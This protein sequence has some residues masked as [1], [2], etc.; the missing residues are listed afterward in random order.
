MRLHKRWMLIGIFWFRI[1]A[2]QSISWPMLPFLKQDSVNPI[3][4]P[5]SAKE[6]KDPI[7][8]QPVRWMMHNVLNPAAIVHGGQI[9]LLFRA[10]D[11]SPLAPTGTSRIGL[12]SSSDGLHFHILPEPV[13]F[14]DTDSMHP[15]EWPGG[16]EDP[17][18]VEREDGLYV[19]TY[20]AYDGHTA[21]LC[22]ATSRD[23]I[24]WKKQ[25]LAF[26]LQ[27]SRWSK[28][29]AIITELKNGKLIAKKI[30][31]QYWMYWGD[32]HIF[33]ATSPDLLHWHMMQDSTG[34]PLQLM[35]PRPYHFDSRLVE[36]GPPPIWTPQGI[37][38]VYNGM[39][40]PDQ[41]RDP[42]LPPN[43]YGVGQAWIDPNNPTRVVHRLSAPFLIPE[44]SYE[45]MGQVN[46]VCFAEGWVW[47]SGKWYLYYGTADSRIA[48]AVYS[49]G[50]G[51]V[52]ASE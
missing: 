35:G 5:D 32:T 14:P 43:A 24:H 29:G 10:Q 44:K 21:R 13:L 8:R 28:S 30:N 33:I 17:R 4:R 52:D 15:Y 18:I 39:N 31:G 6:W 41:Q 12:A 22:I 38:F 51:A 48:V 1:A 25:G 45:R 36:P 46:L 2:G 34:Q 3:L 27:P 23:L 40:A 37:C 26:P 49:P 47:F 16:I 50:S 9:W 11:A 20:T 19:M 7:S 42:R